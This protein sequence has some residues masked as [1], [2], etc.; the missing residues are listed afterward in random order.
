MTK[1][2]YRKLAAGLGGVAMTGLIAA[3]AGAQT[4]P[5]IIAES[6]CTEELPYAARGLVNGFPPNIRVIAWFREDLEGIVYQVAF[7]TDADGTGRTTEVYPA[8]RPFSGWARDYHDVNQNGFVDPGE[9]LILAGT[10]NVTMPCT[11]TPF[12]PK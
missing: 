9:P 2:R 12:A 8:A 11:D 7:Y 1:R 6:A 4:G 10:V 3:P 5:Q